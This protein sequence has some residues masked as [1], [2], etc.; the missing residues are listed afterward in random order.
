MKSGP[1]FIRAHIAPDKMGVIKRMLL[2]ERG[3]VPRW[4]QLKD[5]SVTQAGGSVLVRVSP[6]CQRS[7]NPPTAGVWCPAAAEHTWV[8]DPP[9]GAWP[10]RGLGLLP[11]DRLGHGREFVIR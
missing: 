9:A 11:G 10:E 4:W 3:L 2:L 5:P 6:P 7:P 8:P 1:C